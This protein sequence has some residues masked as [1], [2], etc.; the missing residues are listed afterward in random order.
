[1]KELFG[2]I[3]F[4]FRLLI[5]P[6]TP[7]K[8]IKLGI[9]AFIFAMGFNAWAAVI[10]TFIGGIFG[11]VLQWPLAILAFSATQWCEVE[12]DLMT[13]G[14]ES[15]ADNLKKA[16]LAEN[17]PVYAGLLRQDYRDEFGVEAIEIKRSRLTQA[18]AF[19][20]DAI[21]CSAAYW[22]LSVN[23]WS[24]LWAPMGVLDFVWWKA[25]MLVVTVMFTPRILISA[26]RDGRF[27]SAKSPSLQEA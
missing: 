17:S 27:K 5:S 2:K 12:P 1:M 3:A 8:L 26:M 22:P 18:I 13:L 23:L 4:T 9:L 10:G 19:S 15:P 21:M 24:F 16:R 14:C 6:M 7:S 11:A 25:I 20:V